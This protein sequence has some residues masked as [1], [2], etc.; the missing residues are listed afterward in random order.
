MN[1]IL[2][3]GVLVFV[4]CGGCGDTGWLT[5]N[6]EQ[7]WW[8]GEFASSTGTIGNQWPD[9]EEDYLLL[10]S[11][12]YEWPV[13]PRT[14]LAAR[15]YPVFFYNLRGSEPDRTDHIYGAGL[16]AALRFY[17]R[18]IR[19]KGLYFELSSAAVWHEEHLPSNGSSL[20]FLSGGGL[21]Y[22]FGNDWAATVK[23]LHLSNGG[24]D[25]ENSGLNTAMIGISKTF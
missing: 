21:G 7:G 9:R 13:G 6:I 12:D 22:D 4:V 3:V 23:I 1:R 18:Q 16:G 25:D 10:A 15:G 14:T 11:A 19:A 24:L 2:L 17:S 8:R 20:N 5:E